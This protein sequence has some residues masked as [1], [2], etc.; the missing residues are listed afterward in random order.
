MWWVGKALTA[1]APPSRRTAR[2]FP[3]GPLRYIKK[4]VNLVMCV[5]KQSEN[6]P[7]FYE[8]VAMYGQTVSSFGKT[9][10]V[11]SGEGNAYLATWISVPLW[12]WKYAAWVPFLP[13]TR[14]TFCS[15]TKTIRWLCRASYA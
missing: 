2:R 4:S 13:S 10:R 9:V 15:G 6:S 7:F 8:Y 1:P 3:T 14:P 12:C 5:S 11:G